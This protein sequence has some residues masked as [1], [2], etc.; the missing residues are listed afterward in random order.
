M[1][2]DKEKDDI[3]YKHNLKDNNASLFTSVFSKDNIL[4]L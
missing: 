2:A 1:M 4:Y 3:R